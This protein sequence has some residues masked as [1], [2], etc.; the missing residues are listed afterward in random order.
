MTAFTALVAAAA[1]APAIAMEQLTGTGS[2]IV[3][4]PHPDDESLAMGGAIAAACAAGHRVHVVLVTDGSRS[5]PN[6]ASHPPPVL[7]ALRRREAER[8]VG[9]LTGGRYPPVWLGY[10]DMDAPDSPEVFADVEARLLPLLREATALWTTWNGD[11]HP[12][13]QRTWRLGRWIA[14]R[15]ALRMFA[16]PVW[17]RVQPPAVSADPRALGRFETVRYR[18][19]KARAVAAHVSQMTR[20]ITDDPE[21]FVM[22]AA[23]AAHFVD[24]D[25]IVVA[26]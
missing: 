3:L 23:L 20:L 1:A 6:S 14:G 2:V 21:G 24:T 8:A 11:P 16:F 12:D 5:H 15:H 10:R 4:S 18:A 25:E 17:G 7:A 22:P 19:A 9:I 26:T 13:H